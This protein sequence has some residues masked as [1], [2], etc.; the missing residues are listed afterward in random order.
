MGGGHQAGKA[1]ESGSEVIPVMG[2]GGGGM[3]RHADG[4]S[5]IDLG[6]GLRC[7]RPLG[8]E[9]RGYGIRG[10]GEGGLDAHHQRF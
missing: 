1:I 6:P 9:G 4:K 5:A 10:G 7:Q 8:I 2:R 3:H